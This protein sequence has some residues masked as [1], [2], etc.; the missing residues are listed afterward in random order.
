MKP[1]KG[2]LFSPTNPPSLKLAESMNFQKVG[3]KI[4]DID[5]LEYIMKAEIHEVR[6][7]TVRAGNDDTIQSNERRNEYR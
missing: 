5:G 6:T 7:A 4:D 1:P 2:R 3:E